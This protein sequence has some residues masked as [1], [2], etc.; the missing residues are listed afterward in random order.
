MSRIRTIASA[1]AAA[2][3]IGTIG[4]GSAAAEIE[5]PQA[6]ATIVDRGAIGQAGKWYTDGDGRAFLTAGVN[7]VYKHHPYTPE[8]GGFN[9]DDAQWLADNGFDSV[10]LGIIWKAVEPE[11][12]VYDDEYLASIRRTADLLTSRGI[13]VLIDAHQDM[14]N[15]RFEGEFAPDWAVIDD[16]VPSVLKVGFPT[17]QVVNIGL[18]RA[19]DN[20]LANREGPGGVGLQDRYANMWSHVAAY[21]ADMPGLMGFD[22]I[23]EPWPGSAYPLCYLAMGDCGPASDKLNELH[24]KV[25]QAIVAQDPDAI[26]HYEPYSMWNMGFNTRPARPNVDNAALSWHVYC[27]TN[28]VAGTYH[29]CGI[30][31]GATFNNAS[32]LSGAQGSATLLSEFGATDDAPTLNGVLGLAREHITGW[33]Y[34]SYCGCNDPTT[35][36]QREQGIVADPL[37]PG[38][39]TPD[40]VNQDKLAILAAPHARAVAGTPTA[41]SWDGSAKVYEVSWTADRVDGA[42]VFGP[43]SVSE[44]VVPAINFPNGYRVEV[45]GGQVVSAPNEMSLQIASDGTGPV[46]VK[47]L[48]A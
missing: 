48:P 20:F 18:L 33:Q 16:G 15:E 19:Y 28:A 34:W 30:P 26:V 1:L 12:G 6:G 45:T 40:A 24:E 42:G 21:F 43:G 27:P 23:N 38:P 17:N 3:L 5:A 37:V 22:I 44:I 25:G 36:N 35:Q 47:V 7:M 29:G 39:V 8:A 46:T 41:T 4:A 32:S 10:R 14:Y 13:A 31:D 9:E 11:P 2:A